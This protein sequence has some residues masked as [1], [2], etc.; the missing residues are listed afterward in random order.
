M[1][2]TAKIRECSSEYGNYTRTVKITADTIQSLE[3]KL[4]EFSRF[5]ECDDVEVDDSQK[6]EYF[7]CSGGFSSRLISF[8]DENG[9][10]LSEV[11]KRF[12]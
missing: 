2:Y 10:D 7:N 3:A 9:A 8:T 11:W 5:G 1:V 12:L 4:D 6:P